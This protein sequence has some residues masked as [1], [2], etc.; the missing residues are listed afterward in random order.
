[1]TVLGGICDGI[2]N[3]RLFTVE[4]CKKASASLKKDFF[5]EEERPDYPRGCHF[6]GGGSKPMVYW[7]NHDT[8]RLR[9]DCAALCREPCNNL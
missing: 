9:T 1:M 3:F 4:E 7:N 6:Y 2:K 8:G 5:G